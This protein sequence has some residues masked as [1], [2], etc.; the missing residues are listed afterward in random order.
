MIWWLSNLIVLYLSWVS[1]LIA[2]IKTAVE[3]AATIMEIVL[4]GT[5]MASLSILNA[6]ITM[7]R[8][9]Q[10]CLELSLDPS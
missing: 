3:D 8:I 7:G 10:M 6:I 1:I 4:S 2:T 9:R 5:L